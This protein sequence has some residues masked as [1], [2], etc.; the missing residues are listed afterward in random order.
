M[1]DQLAS[2]PAHRVS[3]PRWLDLRLLTG[4]LLVL[5][6]VVVGARVV[7]TSHSSEPVWVAARD[8]AAGTELSAAD[9]T[10]GRVHLYGKGGRYVSAKGSPPAGYVLTRPV[11]RGE[12]LPVAAIARP[13][14][15]PAY[16]LVTVQVAPLRLPLHLGAGDRVD[17]YVTSR[18]VGGQAV[19]SRLVYAGPSFKEPVPE[20]TDSPW[21]PATRRSSS[22]CRHARCRTWLPVSTAAMSTSSSFLQVRHDRSGM[23]V[24][25]LT[26]VTDA[27]RESELVAALGADDFGVAVVRRCVDLPDLIATASAG[28]ARAVV[29]SAELRRLDRD[30][31]ARLAVSHVAVVALVAPG[32]D[33]AERRMHQLGVSHVLPADADAAA[34]S[35]AVLAAVAAPDA[36]PGSS[37]S[38]ADPMAA[39]RDL[40]PAPPM[41]LPE[42]EPGTGRLVAVWGPTG[43]PGRTSVAV[44]LASEC[45]DLGVATLLADADSYGGVVAQVLGLVDES[46]GLAGAARLANNGVLDLAGLAE[47]ARMVG[48]RLRVLTGIA[49]ADRWHELRPHA[50]E[51]V[52]SLARSLAAVTVVDCGFGLEQDEELSYDTAAPRRNGATLATLAAADTVVAVATADPVG[53]QRFVRGL[54]DLRDVVPGIEPLVVVNRMRRGV[55]GANPEQEIRAALE[56]Y[57]GVPDAV[58]VPMDVPGF[59]AAVAAGRT[60]AEAAASSPARPPLRA[61]AARIA[62]VAAPAGRRRLGRRRAQ[63]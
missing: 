50:L 35:S 59:D 24:P 18:P 62:G 25:V 45:A 27:V 1:S 3:R 43:A 23:S 34:V 5:V 39:L 20:A 57:A 56:Q 41:E 19:S 40:P 33:A 12:M 54:A 28:T 48:P 44:N 10:R 15:T 8:L 2:P 51:T 46:P 61:L 26:A 63:L 7:A 31:L 4:V 30:A 53:L 9:L 38:F 14:Q 6:S 60:L 58:F 32:D 52:W 22:R 47:L 13:G 21:A 17:V 29:L 16:R 37:A 42:I 55:V 36:M 49:R 11:G